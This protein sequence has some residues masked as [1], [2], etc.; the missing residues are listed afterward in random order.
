KVKSEHHMYYDGEKTDNEQEV[1]FRESIVYQNHKK[2]R[3]RKVK[4]FEKLVDGESWG[5]VRVI[6]VD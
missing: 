3:I 5:V 1:D 2:W 6:F 4:G